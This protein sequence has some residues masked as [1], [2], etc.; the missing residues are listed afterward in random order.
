MLR[1]ILGRKSSW[2]SLSASWSCGIIYGI[3]PLLEA[4]G[5]AEVD[6]ALQKIFPDED[7]R[8]TIIFYDK[9][10]VLDRYLTG[11]GDLSWVGTLLIVDRF[12]FRGHTEV[13]CAFFNSPND[14]DNPLLW[15]VEADPP[16]FYWNS[17]IA[18][19]N[20]GWLSGFRHAVM[21]MPKVLN[22]LVLDN[23]ICFKN[24]LLLDK[25]L[26]SKNPTFDR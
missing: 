23:N 1:G 2:G 13:L 9:A 21:R 22:R 7:R 26:L 15:N 19:S 24:E 18:E 11:K 16:E 6:A 8:P 12:H 17:S 5:C 4:E 14:Q 10:C 25:K 20:N 3:V